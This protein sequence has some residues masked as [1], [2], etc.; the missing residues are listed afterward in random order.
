MNIDL[1]QETIEEITKH[2]YPRPFTIYQPATMEIAE[3][4][5][6]ELNNKG[7]FP[8]SELVYDLLIDNGWSEKN[9]KHFI[10][11]LKRYMSQENQE[12]S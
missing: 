6:Q 8:S 12:E 10:K 9:A 2:S 11:K 7:I 3:Q 1:I 5:L 4:L